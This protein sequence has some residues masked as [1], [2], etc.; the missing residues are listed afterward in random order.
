MGP[1]ESRRFH[2]LDTASHAQGP[3]GEDAP[4]ELERR[5]R[6]WKVLGPLNCGASA[7]GTCSPPCK[8]REGRRGYSDLA[9]GEPVLLPVLL[10]PCPRSHN[11]HAH[12]AV[13]S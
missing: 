8:Q 11:L 7:A 6:A 1:C 3:A 12:S 10:T 13:D 9:W 4:G 2:A 5:P